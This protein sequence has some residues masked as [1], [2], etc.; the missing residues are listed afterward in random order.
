MSTEISKFG[1]F[2]GYKC[3][4]ATLKNRNGLSVSITNFGAAIQSLC[5]LDKNRELVDVVLG[6]GSVEQY[7]K[8]NSAFGAT[9]GRVANRI[10]GA[11]FTL[12]GRTFELTKNDGNNTLHGG[13]F[14]FGKR[15][16]TIDD[17]EDGAEPYVVFGYNSPDEEENFPGNLSVKAKYTLLQN[18]VKIQYFGKC[19]QDTVLNLTNHAY[20]NLKGEGEGDIKDHLVKICADKY[21]P[22]D[23]EL[24]PTGEIADVTGT[25]FDFREPKTVRT[26]MDN[27]RLPKGYD[28]N[29]LLGTDRE[30][31]TAAYIYEQT[32]GIIMQVDTDMPAMQFYV[33]IGLNQEPGKNGHVYP[34]YGGLCLESQFCPDSPNKPQFPSCV[35][36]ADEEG[37]Y[38]TTYTFSAK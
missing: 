35:L 16:W 7:E 4:L 29:Y 1:S 23:S 38:T 18:G 5:V 10:G 20:F 30:M 11:K 8:G 31:R 6:Y 13:A 32:R 28:H 21:T 2:Q 24:I 17:I 36:R 33:G 9:V 37:V 26:E 14:G 25:P 27:G 15:M 19:D 3:F 22:V 12:D 34:Q